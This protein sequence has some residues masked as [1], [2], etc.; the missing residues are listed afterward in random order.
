MVPGER[1]ELPTNGLQNRCSTTELTRLFGGLARL[2]KLFAPILSLNPLAQAYRKA[3]GPCAYAEAVLR[4]V[5]CYLPSVLFSVFPTEPVF[6]STPVFAPAL[7]SPAGVCAP[8][9]APV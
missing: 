1:F 8:T 3:N 9:L 7:A 4:S 2:S 5:G 6:T